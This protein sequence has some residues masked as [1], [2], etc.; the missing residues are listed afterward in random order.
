MFSL[1]AMFIGPHRYLAVDGPTRK[2]LTLK[3][4]T[5][6]YTQQWLITG[7]F[8]KAQYYRHNSI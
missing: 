8:Q 4:A 7:C 1:R 2:F 6:E 5:R 3:K